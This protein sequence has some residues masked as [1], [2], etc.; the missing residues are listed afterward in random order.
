IADILS[1]AVPTY[2][3]INF[4]NTRMTFVTRN[5]M[6]D[7]IGVLQHIYKYLPE[8]EENHNCEEI[9]K[10]ILSK[11]EKLVDVAKFIQICLFD[12]LIGNNDRHGRNLGIIETS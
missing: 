8:G 6:Q 2:F 9:I 4:E 7:Y 3:L 12:S 10:L 11:T 5:F 1:R